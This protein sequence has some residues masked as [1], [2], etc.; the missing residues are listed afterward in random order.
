MKK[1]IAFLIRYV[2]R[3][4]LQRVAGVG[5]KIASLFYRGS[6]V[7]CPVCNTGFR[8]FLPYGRINPRPNALCPSC[9][10]LERHRLIWVYLNEK[11]DFFKRKLKVLHIA[12]E[13]CFITPFEKIHGE[14]YITAD[15]ES[16]L[17]KVKMDI[18]SIPFSENTFDAVL[19]NHVLEHVRDDIQAMREIHRVLK[20]GG[21]SIQQVPFFNP[22]PATTFEDNTI[23]DPREREKIFGQDDHVRKYGHDYGKR[24]QMAGLNAI[25]D[26]F[27]NEL[28]D[29]VRQKF[30]LVKGEI[31]F[32]GRKS[33]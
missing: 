18:H 31:I 12:P 4:Y 11:T 32:V 28:S 33:L 21:F 2:P 8:T 23:T 27:V 6:A 20:P 14:G 17:A 25:E 30:G 13:A 3:K 24:M 19:C 5:L 29:D 16:P 10:S 15:I 22:V 7:Q 9:L 1:I 26:P